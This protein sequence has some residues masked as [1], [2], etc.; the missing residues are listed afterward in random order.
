MTWEELAAFIMEMPE[1][2]RKRRAI[3]IYEGFPKEIHSELP[4]MNICE[5]ELKRAD[6]S[7]ATYWSEMSE[8][9]VAIEDGD[10]VIE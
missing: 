1:E 9:V 5:A 10:W 3:I 8:G 7:D 6:E 4:H 2:E